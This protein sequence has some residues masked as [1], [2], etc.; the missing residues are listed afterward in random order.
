MTILIIMNIVDCE[1]DVC[2]RCATTLHFNL[3]HFDLKMFYDVFTS[4]HE[5]FTLIVYCYNKTF[6]GFGPAVLK[7]QRYADELMHFNR[8]YMYTGKLIK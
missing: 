2:C 7:L 6:Y 8:T 5:H 1:Y 3:T 4:L